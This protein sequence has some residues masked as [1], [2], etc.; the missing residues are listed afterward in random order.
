MC[1]STSNQQRVTAAL[2]TRFTTG[3]LKRT[4]NQARACES[5]EAAVAG[6]HCS[7]CFTGLAQRDYLSLCS[8]WTT[9]PLLSSHSLEINATKDQ[10]DCSLKENYDCSWKG[11]IIK[12]T[13]NT[14]TYSMGS[15][16]L[17]LVIGGASCPWFFIFYFL[18]VHFS[19]FSSPQFHP[20]DV[21]RFVI[22]VILTETQNRH[23]LEV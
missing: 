4:S 23:V 7:S 17:C 6:T 11:A 13:E 3:L 8:C 19:T 1:R 14:F 9:P 5:C 18:K 22:R 12:L 16:V 21:I 15:L 2:Q 10:S 20:G